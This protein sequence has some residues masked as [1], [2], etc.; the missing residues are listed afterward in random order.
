MARST[1]RAPVSSILYP[2]LHTTRASVVTFAIAC[3]YS[4]NS[5]L[6]MDAFTTESSR[7]QL[8]I[9][10]NRVHRPEPCPRPC[11]QHTNGDACQT[12]VKDRSSGS[13]TC[14]TFFSNKQC[15]SGINRYAFYIAFISL[16]TLS[17][18]IWI[19]L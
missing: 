17:I 6:L 4:S 9:D 7:S 16:F 18:H 11:A 5:A 2:Y 13:S 3:S 12:L 10:L 1:V 14:F 19:R 8:Y 15:V